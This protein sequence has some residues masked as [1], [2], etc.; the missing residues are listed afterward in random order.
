MLS[1]I[2]ICIVD[3]DNQPLVCRIF[4][5][6]EKESLQFAVYSSLDLIDRKLSSDLNS[7]EAYI[8]YLGPA[9][10]I[11]YEYEI[12]GYSSF[13]HIKVIAILQDHPE[14]EDEL[15]KLL[16]EIYNTYVDTLCNPFLLHTV[17]TPKLLQRIDDLIYQAKT[18]N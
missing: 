13:S 12:Y 7:N 15:K 9:I 17:E 2:C 8:G 11:K 14:D 4:D 5:I 18:S 1:V 3:R 16:N 10:S 6:E